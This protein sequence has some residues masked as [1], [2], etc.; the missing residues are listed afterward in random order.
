MCMRWTCVFI[1]KYMCCAH[2]HMYINKMTMHMH[3]TCSSLNI[4]AVLMCVYCANVYMYINAQDMCV[5][6]SAYI[7]IFNYIHYVFHVAVVCFVLCI[8]VYYCLL[9]RNRFFNHLCIEVPG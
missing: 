1:S 3:W 8:H 6:C 2:V 9:R 5:Y 4:R 7:H